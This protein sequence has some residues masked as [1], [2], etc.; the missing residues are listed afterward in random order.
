MRPGDQGSCGGTGAATAYFLLEPTN[1]NPKNNLPASKAFAARVNGSDYHLQNVA[2]LPWYTGGSEGLGTVYSFPDAQALPAPARPCPPRGGR[3]A[4]T[5]GSPA[6]AAASPNGHK[7]IG[8]WSS[9]GDS[10]SATAARA[11][12]PQWDIVLVAFATPDENAPEGTM[13]FRTARRPGRGAVQGRHRLPEEPR[14]A[15]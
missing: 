8:Y 9:Y 3:A 11:I 10:G 4:A 5:G 6:P 7:L 2:L 13:Q 14:P 15:R 1:T 12:S